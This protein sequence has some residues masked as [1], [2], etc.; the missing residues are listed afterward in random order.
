MKVLAFV[1]QHA[2]D[3]LT[4]RL[5]WG[6]VRLAQVGAT[7]RRVT[8]VE[9][10]LGGP[11]YDATIGSS[12]LRPEANGKT[13][14]RVKR[15]VRLTPGHWLV[16]DM[17]HWDVERTIDWHDQNNGRGYS[18]VGSM[19]TIL[20]FLPRDAE[21]I[22]CVEAVASPHGVVDSHRMTTAVFI[23]HC[24]SCGGRDVTAEFFSTPKPLEG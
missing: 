13:G 9:S 19:S 21:R 6:I 3:D 22:N 1:G 7:Y 11:W 15:G 18:W 20:W 17:P 4:A 24:I 10:L 16:I 2:K 5:G 12:T 8:H 14:V 23:A